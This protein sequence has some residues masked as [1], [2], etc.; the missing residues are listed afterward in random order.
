V[1]E[2]TLHLQVKNSSEEFLSLP[3]RLGYLRVNTDI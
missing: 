3:V 2:I 1:S